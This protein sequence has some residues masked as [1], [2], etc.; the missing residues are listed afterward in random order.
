MDML[1]SRC[2]LSVSLNNAG[3]TSMAYDSSGTLHV[4]DYDTAEQDLKYATADSSGMLSSPVTI[5]AGPS[6]GSQLAL[7]LDSSGNPGIAY[8]DAGHKDLKFAQFD[9]SNWSSGTIDAKGNVGGNPALVFDQSDNPRISYYSFTAKTLKMA[10]FSG[11]KW[12]IVNLDA[13][14]TKA[15]FSAI[16]IDPN[17]GSWAVAYESDAA[18]SI[19]LARPKGKTILHTVVDNKLGKAPNWTTH[20]S[21][22][23][24]SND[25]VEITYTDPKTGALK[26]ATAS[27][28]KWNKS[29]V[30]GSGATVDCTLSFD[31]NTGLAQILYVDSGGELH[32]LS[33]DGASW[34]DSI[35][36]TGSASSAARDPNTNSF[37][38]FSDDNGG[39]V[40]LNSSL[41]AP[42]GLAA[43][44]VSSSQVDLTWTDNSDN[45]T[46][47]SLER[48]VGGAAFDQIATLAADA[49]W[50]SDTSVPDGSVVQY[51]IQAIDDTSTSAYSNVAQAIVPPAAPTGL[52]VGVD[53]TG[54]GI[55]WNDP[56]GSATGYVVQRSSD[57]GNTWSTLTTI[58][59]GT[60]SYLDT[61]ALAGSSYDYQVLATGGGASSDALGP[62]HVDVPALGAP[63]LSAS[64]GSGA[65]SIDLSW[66]DSNAVAGGYR[67]LRST[68][69][70]NFSLI[71]TLGSSATMYSD[72]NVLELS[73]YFYQVL[74][75][76]FDGD[77]PA[78]N[79]AQFS[80]SLAAPTNITT[81]TLSPSHLQ[82]N[83]T[84]NSSH[85]D[86]YY[87]W[88]STDG[89]NFPYSTYFTNP[90][91]QML[92]IPYLTAGQTYWFKVQ[93][94]SASGTA[95]SPVV[96]ATMPGGSPGAAP[97]DLTAA[98]SIDD[99][100]DIDLAWGD[101]SSNETGFRVERSTDGVHFSAIDLLPAGI[102]SYSD[103]G[104]T[105]DTTY[106]YRV[107]TVTA[108]GDGATAT[109]SAV[110]MYPAAPTNLI[111][112]AVSSSQINLS[113]GNPVN[114]TAD[115]LELWC[116]INNGQIV[117]INS[118]ISPSA[119][120]YNVTHMPDGSPLDSSTA[121]TF[122]ISSSLYNSSNEA[123]ATPSFA[124]PGFL[125]ADSQIGNSVHL[126]WGDVLGESG[127][128]VQVSS[129]NGST[130][131]TKDILGPDVTDATETLPNEFSKYVFRVRALSNSGNSPFMWVQYV[132]TELAAPTNLT[133]TDIGGGQVRLNWTDNS[134]AEQNYVIEV[135]QGTEPWFSPITVAANS[136][137][138]ILSAGP[139]GAFQPGVTYQ[140]SVFANVDPGYISQRATAS[141]MLSN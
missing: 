46:G 63:A 120:S 99:P 58:N 24:D 57:G 60:T 8:F 4:A 91:V 97:G 42:S 100:R 20:P 110:A 119:T 22:G 70:V 27:G 95:V 80:T 31:P 37:L 3:A 132:T 56:S 69:G 86:W 103:A 124:T 114:S 53:G 29:T 39:G 21:I 7:A 128:E 68:D 15:Q 38:F 126:I 81:T 140:F 33:S 26:L 17:D 85:E 72:S 30:V 118:N 54:V 67:V 105:T 35:L 51:R 89:I 141:W 36:G 104:V 10:S 112:R 11:A 65:L 18:R 13:P 83:W 47:F 101:N 14:G 137:S 92:D 77:G 117:E 88:Q 111:A 133:V 131:S 123:T 34:G 135:S 115:H 49:T 127:Y 44:V 71:A 43:T 116:S 59:A 64:A 62:G 94:F 121:Y 19:K 82:L 2:L 130:F 129:D 78:S 52:V 87:I 108:N 139:Y 134:H 25:N 28:K 73:G 12:K 55:S 16:G 96:H 125:Y 61:T 76:N 84:D 5:D 106:T 122:W 98:I 6:V 45:E 93:A 1:E 102:T 136:T 32:L 113:W 138:V 48:S 40:Q 41:P 66:T 90:N 109:S 74:A 79:T 107:V 9:G 50:Y 23:F 75:F